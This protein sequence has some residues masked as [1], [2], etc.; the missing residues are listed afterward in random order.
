MHPEDLLL[1]GFDLKKDPAVIL[2]A[3]ND[4]AGITAAFNL[5]L[6]ERIN[7]ELGGDFKTD[8]FMHWESYDP[9]SGA[10]K[11]YIVS[12][13]EQSVH[14]GALAENFHFAA[15][16]AIDVELS[17]KYSPVEIEELA[18][19]A[20]FEALQHFSDDRRYF[21]DSLWRVR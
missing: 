7:R 9:V 18:H 3:Y 6:L 14:I 11:S 12:K 17:L 2:E 19:R 10:T 5:N 13:K 4:R 1:T 16:E 8:Q 21:V 20:G 15:W